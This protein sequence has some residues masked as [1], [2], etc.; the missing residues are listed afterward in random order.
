MGIIV[1]IVDGEKVKRKINACRDAELKVFDN[2]ITGITTVEYES[3]MVMRCSRQGSDRWKVE[4]NDEFWE[5]IE[6][7]DELPGCTHKTQ[8]LVT[9]PNSTN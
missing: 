2:F 6:V 3:A 7:Q 1:R 4:Y 5:E 8:T 9:Y